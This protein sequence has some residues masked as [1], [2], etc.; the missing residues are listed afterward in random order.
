MRDEDGGCR[1]EGEGIGYSNL[2]IG[3]VPSYPTGD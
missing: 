1:G 2:Y 3:A